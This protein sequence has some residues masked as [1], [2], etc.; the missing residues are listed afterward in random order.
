MRQ[1]S[2]RPSTA[3]YWRTRL[4]L[5]SERADRRVAVHGGEVVPVVLL[6]RRAAVRAGE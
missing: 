1:V 6:V 5:C 2:S 3:V 4:L